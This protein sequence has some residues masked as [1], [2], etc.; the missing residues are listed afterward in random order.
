[1]DVKRFKDCRCKTKTESQF[2]KENH[3]INTV[4]QA[5]YLKALC[6]KKSGTDKEKKV[7]LYKEYCQYY[8][9]NTHAGLANDIF[10]IIL[11]PQI[12]DRRIILSTLENML[13][14]MNHY[15]RSGCS[16]ITGTIR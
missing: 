4:F 12:P 3:M 13:A 2:L 10:G 11:L 9:E 14:R 8:F 5:K 6:L 7:K 16:C 1:V 15:S